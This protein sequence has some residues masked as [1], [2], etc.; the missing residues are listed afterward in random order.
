MPDGLEIAARIMSDDLYRLN[1]ISQNLANAGTTGYKKEMVVARPFLDY[2]QKNLP[3]N[4][5]ALSTVVDPRQGALT[6]TGQALDLA[7]EGR[8][9]FELQGSE[10]PL[11]TRQGSFRLDGRGRLVTPSGAPLMGVGGEIVLNGTQPNIDRQGRVLEGERV[12]AQLKVVD[13]GNARQLTPLGGGLYGATGRP[14]LL[15]EAFLERQG[16]LEASNV[17]TLPEMVGLIALARR[18][19]A[20]SRVA[21]GYDGMLGAA[22]RVAEF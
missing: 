1:V 4:M 22:L 15:T 11:Y 9:F 12:V 6:Q 10:G 16:Y 17:A 8:G 18:F 5:P 13:F 7:I 19:E 2:L 21:Q 3:V 14:E 20:A